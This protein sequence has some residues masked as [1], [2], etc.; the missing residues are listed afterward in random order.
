MSKEKLDTDATDQHGFSKPKDTY[1]KMGFEVN[2]AKPVMVRR[3]SYTLFCH[4][5]ERSDE[6]S[7][8]STLIVAYAGSNSLRS[9]GILR[10]AQNDKTVHYHVDH[11]INS[12]KPFVFI[13]SIRIYPCTINWTL[14]KD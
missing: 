1:P 10:C 2:S 3:M 14:D 7:L 6:E 5:E 13:R 8:M 9:V 11:Y 4:S 12:A